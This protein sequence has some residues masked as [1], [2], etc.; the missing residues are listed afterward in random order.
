MYCDKHIHIV[1]EIDHAY[2]CMRTFKITDELISKTK[3]NV[4]KKIIV[5]WV[6]IT[7]YTISSFIWRP[8][9]LSNEKYIGWLVDKSEDYNERGHQDGKRSAIKYCGLKNISTISNFTI[10][11]QWHDY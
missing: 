8:H 6:K 3:D 1:N 7:C 5:G 11:K 9:C 2:C 4:Y 10:E